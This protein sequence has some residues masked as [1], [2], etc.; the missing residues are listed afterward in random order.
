MVA[1]DRVLSMGPIEQSS[2]LML[3]RIVWSRTVFDNYT[4]LTPNWIVRN[5]TVYMYKNGFDIK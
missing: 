3:N 2:V 1:P 5:R 4:V